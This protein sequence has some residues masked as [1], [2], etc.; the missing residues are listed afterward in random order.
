MEPAKKIDCSKVPESK[1]EQEKNQN[2]NG[3][4]MADEL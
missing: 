2:S 3:S 1:M 4:K